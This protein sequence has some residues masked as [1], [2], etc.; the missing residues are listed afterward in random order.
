MEEE[1]I[2]S[3]LTF[4][5]NGSL[6]GIHVG[7]VVE[8][9]AYEQP[10]AKT[11]GLPYMMGLTQHRDRV[12]PLI[13]S[14]LKFGLGPIN[15]SPQ[16]YVVVIAVRNGSE[17]FDVAL[18][19]DQVREVIEITKEQQNAIETNYKPGYVHFAAQTAD[20]LGI[21]IDADKVFT[22]MD[23][24]SMAEFV[25]DE[26]LKLKKQ[27]LQAQQAEETEQQQ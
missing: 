11:M 5:V 16:T 14:G 2:N 23:V 17:T 26:N 10:Q 25:A 20:G 7:K 4:K 8:I 1:I 18:A 24:V 21:F 3:Y 6:C 27:A 19:V 9:M 22:D 12:V 13:D 15:I